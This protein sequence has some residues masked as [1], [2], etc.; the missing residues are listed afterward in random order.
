M[1]TPYL[2]LTLTLLTSARW[3]CHELPS[4]TSRWLDALC[5]QPHGLRVVQFKQHKVLSAEGTLCCHDNNTLYTSPMFTVARAESISQSA[6]GSQQYIKCVQD[7]H[8]ITYLINR[9]VLLSS[10]MVK[11]VSHRRSSFYHQLWLQSQKRR[12]KKKALAQL[13]ERMEQLQHQIQHYLSSL[14]LEV[15]ERRV[16]VTMS[17]LSLQWAWSLLPPQR[18][19]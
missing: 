7:V 3:A 11:P 5:V 6:T 16:T 15:E 18:L 17:S 12:M 14:R 4:L 9:S 10:E 13:A 8:V 2:K 19:F 1:A